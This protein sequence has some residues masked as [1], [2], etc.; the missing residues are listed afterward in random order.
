MAAPHGHQHQH[1]GE[2]Q[3]QRADEPAEIAEREE[4]G[5]LAAVEVAAGGIEQ[6]GGAQHMRLGARRVLVR[7]GGHGAQ[8]DRAIGVEPVGPC[9]LEE[10]ISEDDDEADGLGFPQAARGLDAE[11]ER[12]DHALDLLGRAQQRERASD[13]DQ[14]CRGEECGAV[15]QR[16]HDLHVDHPGLAQEHAAHPGFPVALHARV[17]RAAAVAGPLD[18]DGIGHP[19]ADE[20]QHTDDIETAEQVHDRDP[21]AEE[22]RALQAL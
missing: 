1:G 8:Q 7:R 14:R 17:E 22:A 3:D 2:D 4:E 15:L 13:R 20:A 18:H 11:R 21:G 19:G 6:S 12:P 5:A 16:G 10:R 9:E